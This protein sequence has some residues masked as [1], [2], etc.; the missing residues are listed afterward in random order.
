MLNT[1]IKLKKFLLDKDCFYIGS[2]FAYIFTQISYTAYT[3]ILTHNIYTFSNNEKVYIVNILISLY[4]NKSTTKIL[5]L[6]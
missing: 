6:Q 4:F 1:T 5:C 3:Y 2:L